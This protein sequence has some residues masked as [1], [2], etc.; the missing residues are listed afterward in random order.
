VHNCQYQPEPLQR[1]LRFG[2]T[3]N[4]CIIAIQKAG[5]HYFSSI[6]A[7]EYTMIMVE[8]PPKPRIQMGSCTELTPRAVINTRAIELTSM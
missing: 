6:A 2:D 5:N 4:L 8:P 7:G 3:K 1:L